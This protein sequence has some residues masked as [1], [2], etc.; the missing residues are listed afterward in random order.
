MLSLEVKGGGV[1]V[2]QHPNQQIVNEGF[3]AI[4][5][6]NMDDLRHF[7]ADDIVVHNT[8]D[9]PLAGDYAGADQVTALIQHMF[10]DTNNTLAFDPFEVF[11]D[12][13]LVLIKA[14]MHA[15]RKG[16]VIDLTQIDLV[17]MGDDG[18]VTEAWVFPDDTA[19]SDAF[20]S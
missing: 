8:G 9:H 7:M 4:L 2:Y 16:R 6:D 1:D 5:G 15:E 20:W 12:D 17:Q 11:A 10:E 14:V 13:E 3:A 19:A 18:R